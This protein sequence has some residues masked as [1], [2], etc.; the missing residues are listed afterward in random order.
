MGTRC[1]CLCY[2]WLQTGAHEAD[3][4][5]GQAETVIVVGSMVN[6]SVEVPICHGCRDAIL[7]GRLER[8]S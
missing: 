6:G 1:G 7:G 2:T 5:S 3:V 8:A 4:C